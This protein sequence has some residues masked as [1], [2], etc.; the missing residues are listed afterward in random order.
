MNILL[1]EQNIHYQNILLKFL[2]SIEDIPL[3]NKSRKEYCI[4]YTSLLQWLG[5]DNMLIEIQKTKDKKDWKKAVVNLLI[6]KSQ[7]LSRLLSQ[8]I[9]S[10]NIMFVRLL[11]R[12]NETN[13]AKITKIKRKKVHFK[14]QHYDNDNG[15]EN[16]N[17]KNDEYSLKAPERNLQANTNSKLPVY[18]ELMLQSSRYKKIEKHKLN[19][20]SSLESVYDLFDAI[21]RSYIYNKKSPHSQQ[22]HDIEED[23]NDE[24]K[25][26]MEEILVKAGILSRYDNANLE[27]LSS[28]NLLITI[29]EV[30]NLIDK[31]VG[32][33][34]GIYIINL[35]IWDRGIYMFSPIASTETDFC[36]TALF[37]SMYQSWFP[38]CKSKYMFLDMLYISKCIKNINQQ[39]YMQNINQFMMYSAINYKDIMLN[40]TTSMYS[41][42]DKVD[43]DKL[44]GLMCIYLKTYCNYAVHMSF[45][46]KWLNLCKKSN[47]TYKERSTN[48]KSMDFLNY[49]TKFCS[50]YLLS[51]NGTFTSF[52]ALNPSPCSTIFLWNLCSDVTLIGLEHK[53]NNM[54]VSPPSDLSHYNLESTL[55]HNYV[56][57]AINSPFISGIPEVYD[58]EWVSKWNNQ[59]WPLFEDMWNSYMQYNY[60]PAVINETET[61]FSVGDIIIQ[62]GNDIKKAYEKAYAILRI[63]PEV[64][65][66][67]IS[68]L[69]LVQ[70]GFITRLKDIIGL[71][72][73]EKR[74]FNVLQGTN[75]PLW[76]EVIHDGFKSG[77]NILRCSDIFISKKGWNFASFGNLI[78]AT[79]IEY[80]GCTPEDVCYT[81]VRLMD[82][83]SSM[84][85]NVRINENCCSQQN[86]PFLLNNTVYVCAAT[87][88]GNV[89]STTL[90]KISALLPENASR[91]LSY[92]PLAKLNSVGEVDVK[93][94][95]NTLNI[96]V[97]GIL[98]QAEY[99]TKYNANQNDVFIMKVSDFSPYNTN[100]QNKTKTI[101]KTYRPLPYP[102]T[103][104]EDTVLR[105]GFSGEDGEATRRLDG[106]RYEI[107]MHTGNRTAKLLPIKDFQWN[108]VRY[109][110]NTQ[111]G[112]LYEKEKDKIVQTAYTDNFNNNT[113]HYATKKYYKPTFKDRHSRASYFYL[114]HPSS[115]T[116]IIPFL[117]FLNIHLDSELQDAFYGLVCN[118][119]TTCL[120]ESCVLRRMCYL[121]WD[122]YIRRNIPSSLTYLN[123]EISF[124]YRNF[125]E[126]VKYYYPD[127]DNFNSDNIFAMLM[128]ELY[129]K[130]KWHSNCS[131]DY[132]FNK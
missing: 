23:N 34:E 3:Y 72:I 112:E 29:V 111:S 57:F 85:I 19:G 89:N 110:E 31:Y 130:V 55:L 114:Y 80:F 90:V 81:C 32:N 6:E 107:T 26:Q 7:I 8:Q 93:Y 15:D 37:E 46:T 45:F 120:M 36:Q 82:I 113:P 94:F 104:T 99:D 115:R 52:P 88:L 2:D 79:D 18:V 87:K 92:Q 58:S 22:N 129:K 44:L 38:W 132:F 39:W 124:D 20:E 1:E 16:V 64:D 74:L 33:G 50:V 117:T 116:S 21:F 119:S 70:N 62:K 100:H 9:K 65:Y 86:N 76:I 42:F 35:E 122:I 25:R 91:L 43:A 109:M 66:E 30:M 78:T 128:N 48:Y 127:C 54:E 101:V 95:I 108:D 97:N 5:E 96:Q 118:S 123:R 106:G 49:L 59:Y 77:N 56:N 98:N 41:L 67:K 73:L 84:Q 121:L 24:T 11:D 69:R 126:K 28:K 12:F 10:H 40:N 102:V 103:L 27:Q 14:E 61:I 105:L 75:V 71:L 60:L 51:E 47:L 125:V 131:N 68:L 63:W 17:N 13:Y 83:L 53:E 4:P